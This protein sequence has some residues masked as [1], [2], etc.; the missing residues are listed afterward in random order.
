MRICYYGIEDGAEQNIRRQKFFNLLYHGLK[1]YLP[2]IADNEIRYRFKFFTLEYSVGHIHTHT[3]S[4]C[5][6]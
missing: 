4:W 6:Y 1:K 3:H 5:G 2:K